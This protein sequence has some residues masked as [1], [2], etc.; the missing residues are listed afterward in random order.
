MRVVGSLTTMPYSYNK[1]LKSLKSLKNQTLELDEIYLTVPKYA[2]RIEQKYPPI[3][4]EIKKIVKILNYEDNGPITKIIGSL[5]MEEDP[6]T[7]IITFDD[8][9]VYPRELVE[10]LV[11]KH[12]KNPNEAIGTSGLLFKYSHPFWGLVYNQN[13]QMFRMIGPNIDDRGKYVDSIYGYAG[14]LYVRKFFP[15][16]NNIGEFL[17]YSRQNED[18]YL[19]D[20]ITISGYLSLKNI[21]RKVFSGAP[22]VSCE[23]DSSKNRSVHELS[24]NSTKFSNSLINAIKKAKEVGMFENIEHINYTETIPGNI[25]VIVASLLLIIIIIILIFFKINPINIASIDIFK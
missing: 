9:V 1:L 3:P 6:D 8:D 13:I 2:K 5:L 24:Y 23:L 14:A 4:L 20:D 19:N 11:N 7:I 10:F 21:R 18:L 15:D 16:K 25:T 12:I 22:Q 17:K